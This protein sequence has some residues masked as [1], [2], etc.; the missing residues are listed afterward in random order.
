MEEL[1]RLKYEIQHDRKLSPLP[2]DGGDDI[3]GYN[4]ELEKLGTPSWFGV[5]WLYS[6]CYLCMLS[7]ID[8]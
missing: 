3:K 4:E 5:P 8:I 6:E 7:L 2:E 1:A